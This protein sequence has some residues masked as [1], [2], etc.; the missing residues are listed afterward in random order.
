MSA[1]A[2]PF[3]DGIRRVNGAPL[4]LAGVCAV[5]LLVAL[6]LSL[7]LRGMLEAHL[8]PSLAADAVG[9]RHELRLVAGVLGAGVGPRARPS[10]PSIIG[11]G[12]VLDNL[13]ALLDNLPLAADDRRRRPRVA[14]GLVVPERRHPRSLARG[15]RDPRA[16]LL[17]RLR[18]ALLAVPPAR[19]CSP[20]W[21]TASCSRYVHGW[22]FDGAYDRLT[23]DLTV[24]RTAFAHARRRLSRSSARCWSSSTSS[25]TTRGSDRRRGS[26][27]RAR[28]ARWPARGSCGGTPAVRS[29]LY[30]LNGVA[31]LLLLAALCAPVAPAR[32]A[33]GCAMWPRSRSGRSTSSAGTI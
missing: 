12:A 21:S 9:G 20:G 18:H 33:T 27:Q 32:P 24:E 8:G 14:G 13:S 22:M 31:F 16:R 7:A 29:A 15:R 1:A 4:V 17:R 6:P 30:L 23:R 3:R 25:S 10:C 19:D 5:T 2:P 28:R 11:F 26:A